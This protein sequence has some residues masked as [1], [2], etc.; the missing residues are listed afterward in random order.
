MPRVQLL[1]RRDDYERHFSVLDLG[2]DLIKVM[3]VR[4]DGGEAIVLG[5]G[6]EHMP[7][8]ALQGGAVVDV[9]AVIDA[10]NRALEASEDMAGVVPGQVVV[11]LGG[12]LVKGFSST[13]SYPRDRPDQ[14]VRD[15]ELR[16]LLQLVEKRALREAQ[17][18]LEAERSYGELE[19]RLVHSSIT[20]VR[21]DGYPMIS[22]I[23]FQGRNLE[24]TVF[25][26]FA[27]QSQVGAVETVVHELDLELM[28]AVTGT[29]AI[30]R[31]CA[32][33]ETWEAG[34]TY[35]DVGGTCTEVALLRGGGVEGT[36]MFNLGGRMFTRRLALALGI[37][38]ADA[39]ARKLRHSDGLL[40][41]EQDRQVREVVTPDVDVMLQGL[42]LC[43]RELSRGEE[44]P[45]EI[46]FSGGGSQLPEL[47]D[48][49]SDGAWTRG[50][51]FDGQVAVGRLG[52]EDVQ[53][54]AD[55]SGQISSPQDV[56]P[57]ALANHALRTE[58]EEHD[59]V[60]GVMAGVLRSMRM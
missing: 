24:V 60:N 43:L 27:P 51:N 56:A 52:P 35:V 18:L 31:A 48:R 49:A 17:N 59:E 22:P 13:V 50:L 57:L 42:N 15:Q 3:T 28:A 38:P 2:T 41:A 7:V 32:S 46:Y 26:A 36:R 16:N 58:V 29:Y 20:G 5:V 14:K 34:A 25:N 55:A 1:R 10:C 33:E 45:V 12:E 37:S 44:L 30:A 19:A 54:V 47:I 23:G 53:G 4:R 21:M 9:D 40:N 8:Q 11:S 6:R 39:E